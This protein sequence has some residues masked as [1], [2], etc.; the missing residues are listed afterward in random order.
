MAK[1]AL[2]GDT[3][4][5]FSQGVIVEN[6]ISITLDVDGE[7]VAF[8]QAVV[9]SYKS[10]GC[11]SSPTEMTASSGELTIDGITTSIVLDGDV[12]TCGD[13]IM[14]TSGLEIN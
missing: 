3:L 13:A 11:G 4:V 5:N 10:S 9:S 8:D 1:A 12:N 6:S 2:V 7:E 14:A